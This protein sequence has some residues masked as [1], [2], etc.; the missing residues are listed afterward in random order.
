MTQQATQ[1]EAD[2]GT[3]SAVRPCWSCRGPVGAAELFCQ[4][5]DAL[6]APISTDHFRRLDLPRAF[7]IDVDTLTRHYFRYQRL[8]HPDRF[9]TKS[10]KERALSLQHATDLN[11]AYEI[12][13]DPLSR[14]EYLLSLAGRPVN[15]GDETIDDPELLTESMERREALAEADGAREIDAIIE[16][17]A[18]DIELCRTKIAAAFSEQDIETAAS[19]TTRL[20]YL[21]KLSAEARAAR[22]RI[23]G[24]SEIASATR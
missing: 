16:A 14:A 20:K 7:D 4:T 1:F 11:D 10:A 5:C 2:D 12:L 13:R 9:A 15:A 24:A 17:S 6:Q 18:S 22:A 19:L 3:S 23:G 8:L 21:Q